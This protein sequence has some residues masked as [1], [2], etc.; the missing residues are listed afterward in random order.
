MEKWKSNV[1]KNYYTSLLN[2]YAPLNVSKSLSDI[3]I[4]KNAIP[5]IV[6]SSVLVVFPTIIEVF[7]FSV[8]TLLYF[9]YK[10]IITLALIGLKIWITFKC[11]NFDFHKLRVAIDIHREKFNQLVLDRLNNIDVIKREHTE[12]LEEENFVG[13]INTHEGLEIKIRKKYM[14]S[15]LYLF[16]NICFAFLIINLFSFFDLISKKITNIDFIFINFVL[17]GV[18]NPIHL[19]AQISRNVTKYTSEVNNILNEIIWSWPKRDQGKIDNLPRKY[20]EI[21]LSN[22]SYSYTNQPVIKK[23]SLKIEPGEKIGICGPSGAGKS[24]LCKILMGEYIPS[25]GGVMLDNISIASLSSSLKAEIFGICTQNIGLFNESILYNITYGIKHFPTESQ[26][27]RAIDLAGLA[28]LIAN[29]PEGLNTIINPNAKNFSDGQ[30]QR[31]LM[32]RLFLKNPSLIIL[33]ESTSFLDE[34]SENYILKNLITEF[35]KA[36]FII[37]THRKHVLSSWCDK[38]VFLKEGTLKSRIEDD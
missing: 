12:A 26:L 4:I 31:I 38:I 32:A 20:P 18:I 27:N 10:Y 23:I 7:L 14:H 30:K 35:S 28:N 9:G 24:T 16:L 13:A 3:E 1:L 11:K 22:I 36:T 34:E 6:L 21:C 29:L 15:N 5:H 17:L 8:I 2:K 19:F 37:V 33:D 25:A